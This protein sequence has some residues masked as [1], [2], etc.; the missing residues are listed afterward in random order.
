MI[1]NDITSHL[2][3][4]LLYFAANQQKCINLHSLVFPAEDKGGL[5]RIKMLIIK[6]FLS[7]RLTSDVQ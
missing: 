1:L 2:L 3:A 5:R 7:C 6:L 4:S